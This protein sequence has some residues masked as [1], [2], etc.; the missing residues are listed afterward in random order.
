MHTYGA[1]WSG[2]GRVAWA[3][4]LQLDKRPTVIAATQGA[5]PSTG[6]R[7]NRIGSRTGNDERAE[8]GQTRGPDA[9]VCGLT[10]SYQAASPP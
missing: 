8:D 10:G 7:I 4:A 6:S 1:G 2:D 9:W 3:R 5:P